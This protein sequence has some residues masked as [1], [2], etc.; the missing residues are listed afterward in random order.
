MTLIIQSFWKRL[1]SAEWG[2]Q[3]QR[4]VGSRRKQSR[5][6]WFDH[7]D[8]THRISLLLQSTV[9]TVEPLNL[10]RVTLGDPFQRPEPTGAMAR[11]HQIPWPSH[12]GTVEQMRGTEGQRSRRR[13]FKND[14]VIAQTRAA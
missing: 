14:L 5:V 10:N 6:L 12:G 3:R 1:C 2:D 9:M 7:A 4:V 13:A 8:R 11:E